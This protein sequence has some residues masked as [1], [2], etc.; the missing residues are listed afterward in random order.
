MIGNVAEHFGV[1]IM[2]WKNH[3]DLLLVIAAGS[4]TQIAVFVTPLLVLTSLALG[5]PRD[6]VFVPLEL[7]VLGLATAIF[8]YPSRDGESTWLES[9]Q[10]LAVYLMAG[11]VSTSCRPTAKQYRRGARRHRHDCGCPAT[12]GL[13]SRR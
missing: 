11:L 10:L 3:M 1:V 5:H 9:V 7:L 4:S 2:A 8:A 12:Y 6:L 13:G